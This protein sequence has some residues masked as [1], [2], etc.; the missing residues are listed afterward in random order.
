[1][2]WSIKLVPFTFSLFAY[3]YQQNEA[4]NAGKDKALSNKR[5]DPLTFQPSFP[6]RQ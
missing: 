6:H 4:Q 5:T 1:M 3:S 2:E